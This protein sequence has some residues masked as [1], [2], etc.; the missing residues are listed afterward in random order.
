MTRKQ[1]KVLIRIICAAILLCAASLCSLRL[2]AF[3]LFAS[4]YLVVGYDV[5]LKAIRGIASL[6]P[7]DENFLMTAATV[8]A[9]LLGEYAEATAVML[10]YQTGELFQSVAVGKSRRS[11]GALMDLRPD[12]ANVPDGNGGLTAVSPEEV[13]LGDTVVVLPGEKIP[14]DGIVEEG[15]SSV[16]TA[17]LTGESVPRSVRVG[18]EVQSGCVNL[19]GVIKVRVTKL[20]EESTASKILELVEN[21]SSRKSSSE[22]FITRFARYYTPIVCLC[23]LLLSVVPPI[24]SIL[25]GG[26]G[27]WGTWIYRGL[28][29]LVI[30]CPCALVISIP[31]AFFAAIG[32][33]SRAGILVKGSSYLETLSSVRCIAMDKTGTLTEGVFRVTAVHPWGKITEQELIEYAASAEKSS[34]HPIAKSLVAAVPYLG[35]RDVKNVREEAGKG[36]ISTVDGQEVAVGSASLMENLGIKAVAYGGGTE[37]FVAVNGEFFGSIVISDVVKNDARN[38]VEAMKNAGADR[39]VMLTGDGE[40]AAVRVRD[41]V[42]IDE[43]YWQLL[44]DGKVAALEELMNKGS[45]AV[46]FVGDGINDAP[47]IRRADVGIAMGGLGSDAAIEA[48]DVVIMDD[49]IGKIARAM[50]ISKKCIGIVRFNIVFAVE[51]KIICLLLGAMGY[52]GM[53]AAIFAD[54]GVMVLAVLNSLRAMKIKK[55]K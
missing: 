10:F 28:S 41:E 33:A 1:K 16:N 53:W 11:I 52:A 55:E 6:Q 42:G 5:L 29:F 27:I 17:A 21:A 25:L 13:A 31:L 50:E 38:S 7:F 15:S 47:V 35:E 46:A 23:A 9:V 2:V 40:S 4:A 43:A 44:P 48:A 26:A 14:L 20:F 51:V 45:G 22:R 24:I 39:V 8:G 54:V 30:S 19:S 3:V 49:D 34:L 37:V 36:I 32:G 12:V 18:S